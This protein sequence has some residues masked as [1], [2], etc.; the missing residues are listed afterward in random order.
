M[1]LISYVPKDFFSELNIPMSVYIDTLVDNID[2][3]QKLN[4]IR[5]DIEKMIFDSVKEAS[6]ITNQIELEIDRNDHQSR[7]SHGSSKST[8][9]LPK[10]E[11]PEC[12]IM[13][14]KKGL[15]RHKE[16]QHEGKSLS[17]VNLL[18]KDQAI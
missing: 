13:I 5:H 2:W 9:V 4:L 3:K 11:C 6:P 16:E 17:C 7:A 8:G 14:T 1:N 12:G 15:K 18:P 10:I